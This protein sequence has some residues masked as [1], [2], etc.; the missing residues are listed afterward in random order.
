MLTNE[1]I[2]QLSAVLATKE[3]IKELRGEITELRE[4]LNMLTKSV[5]NL[6][7]A[8]RDLQI[9]YTAVLQKVNR[10]EEWIKKA[11]AKLGIDFNF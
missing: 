1:D 7:K 8:V 2:V 3:D 5:D 10:I 4:S 6:A 9:E 11:S